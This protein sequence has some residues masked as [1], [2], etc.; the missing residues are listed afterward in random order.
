MQNKRN[1]YTL[2]YTVYITLSSMQPYISNLRTISLNILLLY[3]NFFHWNLS[4][5][6]IF[7]YSTIAGVIASI[8]FVGVMVY[9]FFASYREL[10]V[11]VSGD[12][13]MLSHIPTVI[14]TVIMLLCI[15]AVFI[16]TFTYGNFL[17]QNV[18]KS[19]LK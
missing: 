17:L 3:K 18:Y 5:I 19:Y 8:P 12:E 1:K 4:K 16:C 13:F 15:V 2:S 9:Q 7:L 11:S 10:G 6:C 14:I